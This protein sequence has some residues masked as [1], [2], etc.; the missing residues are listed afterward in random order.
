MY[1]W[2]QDFE[3]QT[4]MGNYVYMVWKFAL[5]FD[6]CILQEDSAIENISVD[7]SASQ[8]YEK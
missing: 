1:F 4:S 8:F 5:S 6:Q 7:I 3:L 2:Y